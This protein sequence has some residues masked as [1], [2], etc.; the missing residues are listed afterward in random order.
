MNTETTQ[1]SDIVG[2]GNRDGAQMFRDWF[3]ELGETAEKGEQ[4]AY[5]FVMGSMNE[6][7]K[8]SSGPMVPI[9]RRGGALIVKIDIKDEPDGVEPAKSPVRMRP[10]KSN[11]MKVDEIVKG[12]F[13]AF[14]DSH[15]CESFFHRQA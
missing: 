14:W 1:Q 12:Q 2:R 10:G 13:E 5:V 11:D 15:D 7:L 8:N 4:S 3:A 9:R 6:I